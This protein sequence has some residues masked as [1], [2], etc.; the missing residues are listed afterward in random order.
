MIPERLQRIQRIRELLYDQ[1]RD[2]PSWQSILLKLA[3][4]ASLYASFSSLLSA[5][6]SNIAPLILVGLQSLLV[7][8]LAWLF[9]EIWRYAYEASKSKRGVILSF[10]FIATV[11]GNFIA[12]T[13]NPARASRS[14]KDKSPV[15]TSAPESLQQRFEKLKRGEHQIPIEPGIPLEGDN[16]RV[17]AQ[18]GNYLWANRIEARQGCEALGPGWVIPTLEQIKQTEPKPNFPRPVSLW[19][20]NAS[21]EPITSVQVHGGPWE[22]FSTFVSSNNPDQAQLVLCFRHRDSGGRK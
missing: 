16:W 2:R 5:W 20:G 15:H 11:A 17:L 21:G 6:I 10:A 7:V 1:F 22:K 4:V 12:T 14:G 3:L 9:E 19:L 13:L 18:Q 8:G